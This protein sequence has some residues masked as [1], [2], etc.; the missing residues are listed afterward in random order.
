MTV[1]G[2]EQEQAPSLPAVGEPA[3]DFELVN[4]HG[5]PVRLSNLRGGPVVLVFYPF[6]FSGVCTGEMCALQENLASFESA[7]ATL[8]AV[9]VDSKYTLRA[10]AEAEG[11]GFDLLADFWPHGQ[12]AQRYGVFNPARGM[13]ERGS[14]VLDAE[15]ILRSSFSSPV[16]QARDLHR[17]LDA[18]SELAPA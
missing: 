17:Y 13:A 15:G 7:S 4:Q 14:F 8:L 2:Q 1:L 12:V 9:S 16:G 11:F 3:P 18:L 10:Y 6:A 5:E